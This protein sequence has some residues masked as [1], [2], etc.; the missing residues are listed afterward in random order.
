MGRARRG[1]GGGEVG[2][3]CSRS[4]PPA[5]RSPTR[6]GRSSRSRSSPGGGRRSRSGPHRLRVTSL[7]AGFVRLSPRRRLGDDRCR[8]RSNRDIK[9]GSSTNPINLAHQ[10]RDPRRDPLHRQLRRDHASIP[11]SVCFGDAE[12]ASA[13]RLHR[14]ATGR[15]TWRTS[16]GDGRLDLLL[17]FETQQTGIDPGDTTACLTRQDLRGLNIEGCDSIT[18]QS[19]TRTCSL[20]SSAFEV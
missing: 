19:A 9:P 17:H 20:E 11:A 6:A 12:D 8:S 3:D 2:S 18:T 7:D 15:G 13:A 5:I 4:T 14:G 1:G 10:G 16:N